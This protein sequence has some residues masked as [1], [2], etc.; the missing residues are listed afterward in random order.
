M[1]AGPE[2]ARITEEFE[3]I[4]S[5]V[6][7]KSVRAT[8]NC[9]HEQQ[10]GVQAAFLKDVRSLTAV[11]EEMGNPFLEESQNLLVLDTK[12]IMDASTMADTVRKVQSLGENLAARP[13]QKVNHRHPSQEQAATLQP[14]SSEDR[15]NA[16][17][18]TCSIEE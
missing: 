9:H 4:N 6:A 7:Q 15:I 8:G 11:V 14:P 18:A 5:L 2:I 13:A 16:K 10:P 17:D 1:V 12:D 3:D